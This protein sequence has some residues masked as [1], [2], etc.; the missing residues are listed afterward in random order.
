[1]KDWWVRQNL[2][3]LL[4]VLLSFFVINYFLMISSLNS[5]LKTAVKIVLN[6]HQMVADFDE[7]NI[8][9]ERK[10]EIFFRIHNLKMCLSIFLDSNLHYRLSH[11][12]NDKYLNLKTRVK[13]GGNLLCFRLQICHFKNCKYFNL[14]GKWKIWENSP[15]LMPFLSVNV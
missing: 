2:E 11:L 13:A 7:H 12:N 10:N 14:S 1:M 15:T 4:K 9:K 8:Q 6:S 5:S 3:N